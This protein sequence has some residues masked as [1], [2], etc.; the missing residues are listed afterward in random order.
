MALGCTNRLHFKVAVLAMIFLVVPTVSY[1]QTGSV[2]IAPV[3]DAAALP[4]RDH[5]VDNQSRNRG[6]LAVPA[7]KSVKIDGH[8]GEWDLS[9]RIA[10]FADFQSRSEYS[11][12]TALMW[13]DQ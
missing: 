8:L 5:M 4:G 7:P 3:K 13:D 1:A 6:M 11:V 12:E 9:G 2:S 10:S